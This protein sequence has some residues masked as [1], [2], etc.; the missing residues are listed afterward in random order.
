MATVFWKGKQWIAQWYRPDGTRVKRGTKCEKKREAVRLAAEMEARDRKEESMSG[1]KFEEILSRVAADARAGKLSTDRSADYLVELRQVADPD[2][3]VVSLSDYIAGWRQSKLP[4]VSASTASAHEYMQDRLEKHLGKNAMAAPVTDLTRE[5]IE[6]ALR[7]SKDSGLRGATV[8]QDLRMLRQALKQAHDDGILAKNPAAGIKPFPETDSVERAPF[9]ADEVRRMI[10]HPQTSDEWRGMIL[11]GAHT[12]L[13]LSD[14]ASLGRRHIEGTDI[15][16]RPK[17][18]QRTKKTIRIP[19]TPPLVAWIGDKD[20]PFFPRAAALTVATLSTQFPRIMARAGVPADV[21]LPGGIPARRS[22]HSLRHSFS[23]W[24]AEADIHSDVR[25]KLTG[26]SSA[27]QH[28]RY[29]HHDEA[30]ARAV[31]TLPDISP[32]KRA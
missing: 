28:A 17:K 16:I 25:Q 21:M 1:R 23:S 6:R 30:L 3:K 24:L 2:F 26:H 22:F 4:H 7:K 8:N 19:L 10:D 11:F 14:V 31:A 9:E 5:Q 27:A 29:T 32:A 13:R 12:G 15:V 20:G 18:T